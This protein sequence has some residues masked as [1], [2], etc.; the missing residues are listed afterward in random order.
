V[1]CT[2]KSEIM[3][4]A[5]MRMQYEYQLGN[6]DFIIQDQQSV[7]TDGLVTLL[8][9]DNPEFRKATQEDRLKA[10]DISMESETLKTF[11]EKTIGY[12]KELED[13]YKSKNIFN[14][15]EK[16]GEINMDVK[17]IEVNKNSILNVTKGMS[18]KDYFNQYLPKSM[19]KLNEKMLK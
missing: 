10:I 3:K 13:L 1:G 4:Y 14:S 19:R 18:L 5:K 17:F 15:K 16:Q 2:N 8:N 9:T 7:L 11:M 12:C 6:A